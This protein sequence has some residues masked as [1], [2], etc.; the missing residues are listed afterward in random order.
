[1]LVTISIPIPFGSL[2]ASD[3]R[4]SLHCVSQFRSTPSA[5]ILAYTQHPHR[6]LQSSG[7]PLPPNGNW[8]TRCCVGW[9]G[10]QKTDLIIPARSVTTGEL[11]LKHYG[12]SKFGGK[13][14][15]V[16]CSLAVII[17]AFSFIEELV[18]ADALPDIN[19]TDLCHEYA[20]NQNKLFHSWRLK[21]YPVEFP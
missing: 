4:P 5:W 8:K 15:F 12:K 21:I 1:M 2:M 20:D 18:C 17:P 10:K 13:K 11:I 16:S 6:V 7:T 19:G 9:L 14:V 3:G